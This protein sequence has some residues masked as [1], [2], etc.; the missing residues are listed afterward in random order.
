MSEVNPVCFLSFLWRNSCRAKIGSPL[1]AQY[2]EPPLYEIICTTTRC[3]HQ[4]KRV[5][6]Y[7]IHTLQWRCITGYTS[8]EQ[9]HCPEC[10]VFYCIVVTLGNYFEQQSVGLWDGLE[11]WI[12]HKI[13]NDNTLGDS[14]S[15]YRRDARSGIWRWR[16]R[17]QSQSR[18]DGYIHSCTK[19]Y[20]ALHTKG[21]IISWFFHRVERNTILLSFS[22][23]LLEPA[24]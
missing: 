6:I 8:P 1:H 23:L 16:P 5:V 24:W 7:V 3:R 11:L 15:F 12:K 13:D 17:T 22:R 21:V 9:A 14:Q 10:P 20:P 19:M 2:R 18:W 4:H